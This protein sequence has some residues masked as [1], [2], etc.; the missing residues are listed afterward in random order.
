MSRKRTEAERYR[1]SVPALLQWYSYNAR[2]LP[3][4][5]DPTPYH[6]WISE[7]MLQQTRV[8]AVRGYYDRFLA[9][10]PTVRAVAEASEDRLIKLW[11]GLGYYSRVRNIAKAAKVLCERYGGKLPGDYASLRELPGIGDYTA[12]AIAS[13][14]FGQ[15]V[16]AVDGN[17][18]RVFARLTAY[19][20]DIRSER[21]KKH[22]REM[23]TEAM[24]VGIGRG[25]TA[26]GHFNRA[27]GHFNQAVMDIGATVCIP[28]G[29]PH[30][31]VCPLA[32]LCGAYAEDMTDK[33]PRKAEKKTRPVQKKTVLL[34]TDGEHILLHRRPEQGLLAGMWEF[35]NVEGHLTAGG[36]KKAAVEM[37]N[38]AE[39]LSENAP[40]ASESG[41]A[42]ESGEFRLQAHRLDDSRHAF[43]HVEWEMRGYRIC[44]VSD[45]LKKDTACLD[46]V[47]STNGTDDEYAWVTADEIEKEYGLPTAFREFKLQL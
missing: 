27:A 35:P 33:I 17:V 14:A 12:G 41:N 7:I 21:F 24:E 11:E 37:L 25:S 15:C 38:A 6:V 28:N 43:S 31:D 9:E 23:L 47:K 8:E 46:S 39:H 16:P 20:D 19:R 29:K 4:R 1:E 40:T 26:A 10:F 30:C 18:L 42:C 34:I 13:I 22:V 45:R 2:I 3:W 32:H 5:D 44:I 36:A